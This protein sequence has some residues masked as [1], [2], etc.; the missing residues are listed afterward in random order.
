MP[1]LPSTWWTDQTIQATVTRRFV[2]DQLNPEEQNLVERT[3]AFGDGLTDNTYLDW[4][5]SRS[6]RLFL[7]LLDVGIPD[8]IFGLVDESYDDGDLPI[9]LSSVPSLKL[10]L[11]PDFA[12]DKRFYKAQFKFL[13]RPITEGTHDRFTDDEVIPVEATGFRINLPLLGREGLEKVRLPNEPA[14]A[15]V[16]TKIALGRPRDALTE[17]D[18]L[19]EVDRLKRIRHDHLLSVYATYTIKSD[20]WVLLKPATELTLRSFVLDPPKHFETLPKVERRELVVNWP[21]CLARALAWLHSKGQNHGAIRPSNVLIDDHYQIYLG[22]SEAFDIIG[23]RDAVNDME[24]YQ[25]A[26]PERWRRRATVQTFGPAKV[27]GHSGGRTARK[28]SVAT[29][30]T[31]D[32]PSGALFSQHSGWTSDA[33]RTMSPTFTD[34]QDS[35]DESMSPYFK[36]PQPTFANEDSISRD[37]PRKGSLNSSSNSS[38]SNHSSSQRSFPKRNVNFPGL[39]SNIQ[40]KHIRTPSRSSGSTQSSGNTLK[41]SSSARAA[42]VQTFESAEHSALMSDCFALGAV[43]IDILTFLC[44]KSAAS[45]ARHRSAKNRTAGRGGGLADASFHANLGQVESWCD[46]LESEAKKRQRKD[47]GSTFAVVKPML[48]ILK[49]CLQK[50]PERRVYAVQVERRLGD[51]IW[52]YANVARLHCGNDGQETEH[53]YPEAGQISNLSRPRGENGQMA[54]REANSDIPNI[55]ERHSGRRP[56][57]D[58]QT[59]PLQL[60]SSNSPSE[61]SPLDP[62]PSHEENFD[63]GFNPSDEALQRWATAPLYDPP[64]SAREVPSWRPRLSIPF[65]ESDYG[66]STSFVEGEFRPRMDSQ[67]F[68]IAHPGTEITD[69]AKLTLEPN[70]GFPSP[71]APVTTKVPPKSDWPLRS[72]RR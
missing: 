72:G 27:A 42:V 33:P 45:F 37:R 41:A 51:C 62:S 3:L 20:I 14:K 36:K 9:P 44:K 18:V 57:H 26:P 1:S 35:F 70:G 55:S 67:N 10:S 60:K 71:R 48:D 43:C 22:Q 46:G 11:H 59:P 40:T 5:L 28:P 61:K 29:T 8:Q 16:Q 56:L 50:E 34:F 6:R 38:G 69:F 32:S 24:E 19:H 58:G 7:T 49:Q 39:K 52:R 17:Q 21:H 23:G 2:L 31:P 47:D 12:L 68:P 63:P 53:P 15:L 54:T 4:I 65:S 30:P 13:V 66:D 64:H 25:Y